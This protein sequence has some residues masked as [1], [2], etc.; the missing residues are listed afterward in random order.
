MKL[1]TYL[2]N[3][4]GF[5]CSFIDAEI[6]NVIE[7]ELE[8]YN[9]EHKKNITYDD[10]IINYEAITNEISQEFTDFMQPYYNIFN[11]NIKLKYQSLHSPKYY[12][13]TTDSINIELSYNKAKLTKYIKAIYKDTDMYAYLKELIKNNHSSRDGFASFHSSNIDN[14]LSDILSLSDKDTIYKLSTLLGYILEYTNSLYNDDTLEMLY[15][16][17]SDVYSIVSSNITIN[18]DDL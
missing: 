7:M 9:D 1:Q 17:N 14:W 11:S 4:N 3:F 2:P 10:L 12:N 15:I 5:Y 16:A 6:D 8:Y 18:E 13:Y